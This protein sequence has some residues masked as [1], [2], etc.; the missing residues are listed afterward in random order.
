MAAKVVAYTALESRP[1][2]RRTLAGALWPRSS[3]QRAHGA[4]RT[5]LYRAQGIEHALVVGS[6]AVGLAPGVSVDIQD[7]LRSV[8]RRGSP[9]PAAPINRVPIEWLSKEL[10]PEWCDDWVVPERERFRLLALATL[11]DLSARYAERGDSMFAVDCAMA[12]V[13]LDPVRESA[14]R[15]LMAAHL[16]TGNASEALQQY[17]S[18]RKFLA[19]ELSLEPSPQMAALVRSIVWQSSSTRRSASDRLTG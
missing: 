17:D 16:T 5:T 12:A 4:L 8:P 1:V 18:Y 11:E 19:A 13:R 10:L 7:V 14:H 9:D 15:A 6:E 2:T 3:R